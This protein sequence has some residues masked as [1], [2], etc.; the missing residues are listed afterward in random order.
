M[1]APFAEA[2]L[3]RDGH[4]PTGGGDDGK[5][6]ERQTRCPNA[7][8]DAQSQLLTTLRPMSLDALAMSQV[9]RHRTAKTPYWDPRKAGHLLALADH[10]GLVRQ[11]APEP[12][13]PIDPDDIHPGL[14]DCHPPGMAFQL[15]P[16]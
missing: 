1:L 11:P 12:L 5:Q 4:G 9:R 7:K 15:P 10:L 6:D 3:R 16:A 14:L 2:E 8:L 13:P